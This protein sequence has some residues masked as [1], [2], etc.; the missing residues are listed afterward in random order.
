[1][2]LRGESRVASISIDLCGHTAYSLIHN[3][4]RFS[5]WFPSAHHGTIAADLWP[6]DP[7]LSN[8]GDFETKETIML[9]L[10]SSSIISPS[11]YSAHPF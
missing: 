8:S 6:L 9:D 10:N 7:F 5:K 3:K 11:I 4:Y 1:M 2:I